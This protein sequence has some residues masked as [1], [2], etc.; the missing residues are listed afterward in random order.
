MIIVLNTFALQRA[1]RGVTQGWL[2]TTLSL[3]LRETLSRIASERAEISDIPKAL[4]A[5]AAK[6]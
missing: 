6:R 2:A 3:N 4:T 5:R 1:L